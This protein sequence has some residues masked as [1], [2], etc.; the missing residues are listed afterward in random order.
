MTSRRDQ[1]DRELEDCLARLNEHVEELA[2]GDQ[3]DPFE[4]E[5]LIANFDGGIANLHRIVSALLQD[6][7][8]AAV[9][10]HADLDREV[11]V[12]LGQFTASATV[13]LVVRQQLQ[14]SLPKVA[15]S[16]S[17]LRHAVD[18]ALAICAGGAAPGSEVLVRTFADG[19]QAVLEIRCNDIVADLGARSLT[20][21]AFATSW[22]GRCQ[23]AT[24]GEQG[25]TLSLT[26][27]LALER[28]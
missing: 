20:L 8:E 5:D 13:P 12:S 6:V 4:G 15:C 10:E 9:A 23:L 1:D 18:R 7:A 21:R 19:D 16:P 22:R 27:P 17:E 25:L 14:G 28:H 3:K 24:G 2:R 11:E 26:F